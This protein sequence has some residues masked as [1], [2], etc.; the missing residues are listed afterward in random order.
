MSNEQAQVRRKEKRILVVNHEYPP[1]PGGAAIITKDIVEEIAKER[2]VVVVSSSCPGA[3][4]REQSGNVEIHRVACFGRRT[5]ELYPTIPS[6]V[7]Y[8]LFSL[9]KVYAMTRQYDIALIHSFA[10]IA[11]GVVGHLSSRLFGI[12][13]FCTII[14]AD[15]YS[16]IERAWLYKNRLYQSMI[17]RILTHSRHVISISGEIA[18]RARSIYGVTKAI[19]VIPPPL[20]PEF[21][22]LPPVD[23]SDEDDREFRICSVSRLVKRKSLETILEAVSLLK[24][25]TVHYYAAGTGDQ[26]D[27]LANMAKQLRIEGQVHFMGRVESVPSFFREVRPH[28][29][30]LVSH[31]EGFGVA[32]LE[33]MACGLPVIAGDQGGQTDFIV[34]GENGYIVPVGDARALAERIRFL[35]EN[36]AI[37]KQQ[38]ASAYV[39]AQE[40]YPSKV[41]DRYLR[42][43]EAFA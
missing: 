1:V 43:Y 36:P 42:L 3:P 37:R 31:H 17:R 33:A 41:A 29:F 19:T 20:H 2:K 32:Y 26:K 8:T 11:G 28:V 30:V 10:A 24:D 13:H 18:N 5:A 23:A 38:A 16:P 14:G 27:H 7:S 22:S 39:K 4:R 25:P 6:L 9:P 12:P 40:F 21:C 15:I 34:N 35:K